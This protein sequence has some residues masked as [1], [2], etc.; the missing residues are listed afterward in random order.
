[1]ID[2]KRFPESVKYADKLQEFS[3]KYGIPV[4]LVVRLVDKESA[5]NPQ[6]KNPNGS[7]YGLGQHIDSTWEEING[8]L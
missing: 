6:A 3:E 5:W 2:E 8:K 1:M 7:A 4:D